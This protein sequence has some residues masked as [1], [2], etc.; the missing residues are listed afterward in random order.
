MPQLA[1]HT[2]VQQLKFGLP[3]ELS[4]PRLQQRGPGQHRAWWL[5]PH[6]V[7]SRSLQD[8][9]DSNSGS[10]E[11]LRPCRCDYSTQ[12]MSQLGQP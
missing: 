6:L 1:K 7:Q 4:T 5:C 10:I 12:Q 2:Q 8:P 11:L 3:A 9:E